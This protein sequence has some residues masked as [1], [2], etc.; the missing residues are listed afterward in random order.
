MVRSKLQG[1]LLKEV[2]QGHVHVG[3]T[4]VKVEQLPRGRLRIS[5]RDGF[6]DEV[7]LLVGADGIRSVKITYSHTT[8]R[9]SQPAV[10]PL[11]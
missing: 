1:A 11:T 8:F 7:D 9:T 10:W 2:D 5:F 6:V 4:L 3:K